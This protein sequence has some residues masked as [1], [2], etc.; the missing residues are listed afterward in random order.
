M[1]ALI[2]NF[3]NQLR[4]ALRM[5]EKADLSRTK[6][7]ETPLYNVVIVGMGGSGIGATIVSE[8][9]SHESKI[10]MLASKN[11]FLPS[12]VGR[13]S[14]VIISSYSGNTEETIRATEHALKKKAKIVCIASG[15]KLIEIA[16][17]KNLDHIIIPGGMS[18]RASV[19]Y[20]LVLIFFIL[21]YFG[22][23]SGKFKKDFKATIALLD[24][25]EKN[26]QKEAK[27]VA[28]ILFKKFPI[29]YSPVGHEGVALRLRQQLNENSKMLALHHV[30]PEMNHNELAGW[31]KKHPNL[32]VVIFRNKND[33]ARVKKRIDI[34]KKII[35]KSA[36]DIV[37]IYS[38]GNSL[39]EKTMYH[40][41]LGDYV[42]AYL[43]DMKKIDSHEVRVIEYL[44]SELKAQ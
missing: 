44:K 33:Y 42:S 13:H 1:K 2:G 30:I 25:E 15:G 11:Y 3:S 29:L 32:A 28:K 19:G 5:G 12:Y 24:K 18:P 35:S 43:A 39:I 36:K 17:R 21:H 20:S 16:K 27:K 10:P 6:H 26:I 38:K 37:E 31:T 8:L 14:L 40:I 41:H 7:L 23:I 22:L 9:V 4:D 34:T